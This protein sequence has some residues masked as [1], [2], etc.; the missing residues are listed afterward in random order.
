MSHLFPYCGTALVVEFVAGAGSEN[1][2]LSQVG[3]FGGSSLAEGGNESSQVKHDPA[4]V[5]LA[6]KVVGG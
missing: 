1:R 2:G 5:R 4:D 6:T 3:I